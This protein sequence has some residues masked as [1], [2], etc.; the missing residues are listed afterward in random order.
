VSGRAPASFGRHE[1]IARVRAALGHRA[2]RDPGPPP[3]I[4]DETVRVVATN[5]DLASVFAANAAAVGMFVHRSSSARATE[6]VCGI[7]KA[8]N[9]RRVAIAA[10]PMLA[11]VR[12]AMQRMN[13]EVVAHAGPGFESLYDCDAGVTDAQAGIA[14]TGSLVCAAGPGRGSGLSL[15]PPVHIAIVRK[16]DLVADLI[17]LWQRAGPADIAL[18]RNIILITGPSKTA[19]IEGVLITGVHGPREVHIVLVEDS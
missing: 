8:S 6:V 7:L 11:G 17:D 5:S 18:S 4:P 1:L 9:A 15:V 2:S 10:S 13:L 14:E 16:S 12:E 19:D 3:R